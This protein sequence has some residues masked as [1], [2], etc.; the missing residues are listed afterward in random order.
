MRFGEKVVLVAG[1]TGALGRSVTIAFLSEGARVIAAARN[2]ASF[3]PLAGASGEHRQRLAFAQVDLADPAQTE[4][5]VNEAV[6]GV[7][8][9]DAVVNAV[10]GWSGGVRLG[11]EP[12]DLLERMLQMNLRA[13]YALAKATIPLLARQGGGAFVEIASRA[14]VGPQPRQASYAASKA[15]AVSLFLSLAE[16]VKRE[17]VRVNVLL[18][19]TLD[20][21]ANRRAM[22]DADRS[23]W[24]STEEVAQVILFLCSDDARAIRGAAIPL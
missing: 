22:P 9:L 15:A 16:E 8:R 1:A 13:G 4:R 17:G 19:G 14:A 21:E 2:A 24:L 23:G 20:T 6:R 18:P 5:A 10:G 12:V 3:E 7:G 11:D